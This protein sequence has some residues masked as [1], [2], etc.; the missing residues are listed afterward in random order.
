MYIPTYEPWD[1]GGRYAT[2][3]H[4]RRKTPARGGY[5]GLRGGAAS[6]RMREL[7]G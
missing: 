5:S 7:I 2:G 1:G 4:R 6:Y 3:S